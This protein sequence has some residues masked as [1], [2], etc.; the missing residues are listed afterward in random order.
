MLE[1]RKAPS[2]S[3]SQNAD[4]VPQSITLIYHIFVKN[5]VKVKKM[6]RLSNLTPLNKVFTKGIN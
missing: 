2:I 1:K 6:L 4:R 5:Q 3:K